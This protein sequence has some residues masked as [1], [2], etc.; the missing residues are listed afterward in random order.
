MTDSTSTVVRVTHRFSAS[1][2]R[3]FDAWLTPDT[4]AA[5]M[6]GP[7]A[8]EMI[9]VGVDARVGGRYSFV[10]RRG[11]E[12]IDHTGEYL[13]MDRPR[14]LAFTWGVPT[15]SPEATRVDLAIEPDG[16]GALLTLTQAGVAPGYAERTTMG[17]TRISEAIAAALDA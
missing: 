10:V 7:A 3:V 11:G 15:Y 12:D 17:W 5:W 2:E 6:V 13:V 4:I 1:P 8:G 9:H 14:H 16:P